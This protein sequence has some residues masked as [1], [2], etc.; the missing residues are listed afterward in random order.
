MSRNEAGTVQ[1]QQVREAI[2]F[3]DRD[4]IFANHLDESIGRL[5]VKVLKS[6]PRSPMAKCDL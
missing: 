2:G 4:S 6:P 3:H 5:G 1:L